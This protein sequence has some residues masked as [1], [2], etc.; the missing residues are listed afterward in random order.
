MDDPDL[1]AF[2]FDPLIN[3]ISLR[4]HTPKNAPLVSHEDELDY[5]HTTNGSN[6]SGMD[7]SSNKL[8]GWFIRVGGLLGEESTRRSKNRL[9]IAGE[10]F[11]HFFHMLCWRGGL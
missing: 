6:C 1:P 7:G 8:T 9:Q 10:L 5:F 3:P 4:G 11:I 2:Y